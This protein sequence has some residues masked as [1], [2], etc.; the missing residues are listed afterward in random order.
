MRLEV[1]WLAIYPSRWDIQ[2]L[3]G[4][5]VSGARDWS[6]ELREWIRCWDWPC[7]WGLVPCRGTSMAAEFQTIFGV[8]N[9]LDTTRRIDSLQW[10]CKP[11]H[12]E[13]EPWHQGTTPSARDTGH[14][15][16]YSEISQS[17]KHHWDSCRKAFRF[18]L[19]ALPRDLMKFSDRLEF[20]QH[21]CWL[22]PC[23]GLTAEW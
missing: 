2:I 20:Y 8:A 23:F 9:D 16:D 15:R 1:I 14:I 19:W 18:V 3:D 6:G 7:F 10:G 13:S 17:S 4:V 12:P 11:F 21:I 22:S 5:F